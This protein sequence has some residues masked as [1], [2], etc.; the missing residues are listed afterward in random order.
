MADKLASTISPEVGRLDVD[1]QGYDITN[2]V[3]C[4]SGGLDSSIVTSIMADKM[5]MPVKTFNIGYE[6]EGYNEFRFSR[7]LSDFH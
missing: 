3:V 5:K 4:L 6:E 1:T 7:M 2:L